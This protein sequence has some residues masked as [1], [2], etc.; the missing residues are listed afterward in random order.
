MRYL[1]ADNVMSLVCFA[2]AI[3]AAVSPFNEFLRGRYFSDRYRWSGIERRDLVPLSKTVAVSLGFAAGAFYWIAVS[4]DSTAMLRGLFLATFLI[5]VLG[6]ALFSI[7][8]SLWRMRQ[9]RKHQA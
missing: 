6:T 7:A 3:G 4:S 1:T 2:L 8:Y 9:A 5:G